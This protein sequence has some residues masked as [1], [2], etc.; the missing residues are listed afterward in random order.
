MSLTLTSEGWSTMLQNPIVPLVLQHTAFN[1][2]HNNEGNERHGKKI[3]V[4]FCCIMSQPE[5]GPGVLII[6]THVSLP[7]AKGWAWP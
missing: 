6:I 5:A 1:F 7:A 3:K 4:G 2:V